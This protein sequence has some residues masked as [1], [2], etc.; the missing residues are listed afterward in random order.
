MYLVGSRKKNNVSLKLQL[1]YLIKQL[2]IILIV[3]ATYQNSAHSMKPA[4]TRRE[5]YLNKRLQSVHQQEE[6]VRA[7]LLRPSRKNGFSNIV[8]QGLHTTLRFEVT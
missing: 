6:H 1:G 7:M 8:C 5:A 4:L 2:F 3:V